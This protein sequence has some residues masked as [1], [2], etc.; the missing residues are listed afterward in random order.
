MNFEI[1][2][3]LQF[4]K[5]KFDKEYSYAIHVFT[6]GALSDSLPIPIQEDGE[7][8]DIQYGKDDED[9]ETVDEETPDSDTDVAQEEFEPG[10][11]VTMEKFLENAEIFQKTIFEKASGEDGYL[12]SAYQARFEPYEQIVNNI[13][14][15]ETFS[16]SN[17][18]LIKEYAELYYSYQKIIDYA[19]YIINNPEEFKDA[20]EKEREIRHFVRD[21][22]GCKA[23][24]ALES[25]IC[26]SL[27]DK[28]CDV[29]DFKVKY[30]IPTEVELMTMLPEKMFRHPGTCREHRDLHKNYLRG[31][32]LHSFSWR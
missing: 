28:A 13:A 26:R 31:R 16:A 5:E 29:V 15:G 4:M 18:E 20:K 2:I 17:C 32:C 22:Q 11:A 23:M 9:I 25:D 3:A 21:V 27:G 24:V 19:E 30:D 8:P 1:E 7:K 10:Y 14:P 6:E 12:Y